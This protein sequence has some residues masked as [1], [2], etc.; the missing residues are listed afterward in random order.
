[1]SLTKV[2]LTELDI[3]IL[4]KRK[5]SKNKIRLLILI[6]SISVLSIIRYYSPNET[7]GFTKIAMLII[8]SGLI[9]GSL[10]DTN[11][12]NDLKERIKLVGDIKIKKK[13]HYHDADNNKNHFIITFD[14]WR[15]GDREVEEEF[16]NK[17]NEGDEFYIEQAA[18]SGYVLQFKK[19][20]IDILNEIYN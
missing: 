6:F 12:D 8:F 3:K 14:D 15:I 7:Y 9:I 17:T 10:I 4:K 20:S 2:S 16:W 11:I 19:E 5:R 18:N 13:E 1:M